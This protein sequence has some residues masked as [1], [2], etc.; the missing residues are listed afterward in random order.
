VYQ[1]VGRGS[2]QRAGLCTSSSGQTPPNKMVFIPHRPGGIPPGGV[3]S[4][5]RL[6]LGIPA[7]ISGGRV[8]PHPLA[9][10]HQR[11]ADY[12]Q[13]S[14]H[15]I[16]PDRYNTSLQN[17]MYCQ[18]WESDIITSAVKASSDLLPIPHL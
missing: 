9:G 6:S 14:L 7:S 3:A 8:H 12:L 5:H 2:S 15:N 13:P 16:T 10:I 17:L 18:M 4:W 11:I 1:L